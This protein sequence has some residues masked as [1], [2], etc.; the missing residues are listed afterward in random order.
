MTPTAERIAYR[1][2]GHP[3]QMD[4]R[5]WDKGITTTDS[6]R[7]LQASKVEKS[8]IGSRKETRGLMA[9]DGAPEKRE[10]GLQSLGG[11]GYTA[12][13]KNACSIDA[14]LNGGTCEAC[15]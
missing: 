5:A 14:M 4:R 1:L 6:L 13:E 9:R 2:S 12:E 15:Q 11:V 10:H 3:S 7:T 8:T